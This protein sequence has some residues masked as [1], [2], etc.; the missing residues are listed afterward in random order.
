MV[1][2]DDWAWRK[3][4]AYGTIRWSVGA[5][6]SRQFCDVCDWSPQPS[7]AADFLSRSEP[8]MCAR[9][10]R[11]AYTAVPVWH[12]DYAPDAADVPITRQLGPN[13]LAS[14]N[15]LMDVVA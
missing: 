6:Q 5:G 7:T 9:F 2:T 13:R 4:S 12:S 3:G 15:I 10:D 11:P 14:F 8:T 1:G